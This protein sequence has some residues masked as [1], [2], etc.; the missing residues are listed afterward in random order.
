MSRVLITGGAGF[1]GSHL[2][3][4]LLEKNF[5]IVI[6]D[7]LSTGKLENVPKSDK[8]DFV[9]GDVS[10][11]KT[12]EKLKEA[13]PK[14]KYIFHLAAIAS[15]QQSMDEPLYTHSVNFDATLNILDTYKDSGVEKI[16][17]ASSAAVYGDTKEIPTSETASKSPLSP[18]GADKLSGEYYLKVYNDSFGFPS[19]GCRFFNV[20]GERQDPSSPYSG[21][22]SI[23]FNKAVAK[24]KGEESEIKI[25]GDGEQVRDF[26]YV[27]DIV[28]ALFFMAESKEIKGEIFNLGYGNSI[29]V[30]TL[31]EK[32]KN[33]VCDKVTISH[34]EGRAGDI[35]ESRANISKVKSTGFS[36]KYTLDE[37]LKRLRDSLLQL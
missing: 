7:N 23:F 2:V 35:R 25:Y 10:D 30:N 19:V 22:I 27:K 33:I 15:V 18:Y 8:I 29:S 21:V 28:R 32:I 12:I 11:K 1:I 17:Y 24:L 37:G 9:E 26:I 6:L 4:L 14:I 5:E 3:E 31:A 36:F 20:F 16:V 13:Y 34:V